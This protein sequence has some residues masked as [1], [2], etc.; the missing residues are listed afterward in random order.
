MNCDIPLHLAN[1]KT[2]LSI[3]GPFVFALAFVAFL[4]FAGKA[5]TPL[6]KG[7]LVI[8]VLANV[9]IAGFLVWQAR[10]ARVS[11]S[12]NAL[13]LRAG[14]DSVVVPLGALRWDEAADASAM[15][16][17]FR[18]AGTGLP[19]MH[20]GWFR[21]EGGGD[22]FLLRSSEP[23]TLIPTTKQFDVVIPTTAYE[24]ARK[25][26]YDHKTAE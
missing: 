15:R 22:A 21:R 16:F 25:C 19:G 5:P 20:V 9:A 24:Q 18:K 17:P 7:A 8:V 14:T 4:Y 2:Y 26:V 11:I 10:S 3:F 13:M 23:A 12:G 1:G 6:K